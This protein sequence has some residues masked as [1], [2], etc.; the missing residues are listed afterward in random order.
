MPETDLLTVKT[1]N[2]G[3]T[4]NKATGPEIEQVAAF[5]TL[6]SLFCF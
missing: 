6:W 3:A 5:P 4:C 2:E 1:A